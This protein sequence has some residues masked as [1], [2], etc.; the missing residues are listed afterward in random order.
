MA[1]KSTGQRNFFRFM[2]LIGVVVIGGLGY[3][4]LGAAPNLSNSK[5]HINTS[6]VETCL[7][8]HV[9]GEMDAPIMPH[10]AMGSCTFCHRPLDKA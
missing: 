3:S 4:F 7:K 9:Q 6:S 5:F 10:R 2:T 8:C 1:K